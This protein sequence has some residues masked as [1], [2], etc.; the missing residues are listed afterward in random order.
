MT[1]HERIT[2][3][4]EAR[5]A[6]AQA[7]TPGPWVHDNDLGMVVVIHDKD[8]LS[9]VASAHVADAAFVAANDPARIIRD[10][11]RDLTTLDRHQA[12]GNGE[13]CRYCCRGRHSESEAIR[14]PCADLLSLAEAY[15]IGVGD[16]DG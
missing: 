4:V 3:A 6:V 14:Y 10:C 9:S 7:A 12:T 13:C 2:A 1:L 15:E 16:G 8:S 5:L 11:R